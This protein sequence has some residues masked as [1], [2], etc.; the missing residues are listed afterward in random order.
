MTTSLGSHSGFERDTGH[1][2]FFNRISTYCIHSSNDVLPGN[3][4]IYY[5]AFDKDLIILRVS[6]FD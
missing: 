6:I 1:V 4:A 3:V 5:V 2:D